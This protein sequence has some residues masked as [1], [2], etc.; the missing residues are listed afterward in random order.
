MRE[1]GHGSI[2]GRIKDTIIRGGENIYPKEVEEF[3]HT[4]PSILEAQVFGVPDYRMG[5][6]VAVWIVLKGGAS[7]SE[8]QIKTFCKG[9]VNAPNLV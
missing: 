8:D 3:F 4:H 1:T 5:E 2:V 7:L 6:E 9:K